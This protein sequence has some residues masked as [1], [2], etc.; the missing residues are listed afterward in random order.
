MTDTNLDLLIAAEREKANKRIAKL[1]RAAAIE[2]R[3]LDDKVVELLKEQKPDLYERLAD[4]ARAALD[5][6]NARRSRKPKSS[7]GKGASEPAVG[8][9]VTEVHREEA[10]QP[11]NG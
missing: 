3:K 8:D 5:A 6:E 11:W 1:R 10:Q 2:Q 9:V 7:A 4:D